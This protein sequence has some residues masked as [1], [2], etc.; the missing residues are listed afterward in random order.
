MSDRT[1]LLGCWSTWFVSDGVKDPV[2]LPVKDDMQTTY[3][4]PRHTFVRILGNSLEKDAS[5]S[6]TTLF[7]TQ[8]TEIT[9]VWRTT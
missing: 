4:L 2:S 3:W 9:K 6:A 8:V 1:L 7:S 5:A